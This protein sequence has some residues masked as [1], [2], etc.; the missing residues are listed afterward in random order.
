MPLTKVNLGLFIEAGIEA[1]G[2]NDVVIVIDAL[3][4][5]STIIAAL[6][7]GIIEI[8]PVKSLEEAFELR[9][10]Q[11]D[12]ILVGERAG[13]KPDGFDLGNSPTAFISNNYRGKKVI[14]TTSN[15]TKAIE[16]VKECDWVLIG[17]FLNA[18]EVANVAL[19]LAKEHEVGITILLACSSRNLFLEDF[20]CGG[21]LVSKLLSPGIKLDDSA[22]ASMLSWY[23]AE[24]NLEEIIKNS[25]HGKYLMDI[26]FGKDIDF[27]LN[28]DHYSIIPYLNN[29][30][31]RKKEKEKFIS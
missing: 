16:Q 11:K 15:G 22:Y 24:K 5:S 18:N 10:M 30:N 8:T 4:C 20:I 6:A 23:K 19:K 21:L 1:V 27:C 12:L 13:L 2:R 28:I 9:K 26:G 3:R 17:A 7:N 31:I 14:L 25:Q 29:G